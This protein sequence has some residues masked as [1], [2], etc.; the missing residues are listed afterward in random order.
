[1]MDMTS[2]YLH[3]KQQV[4]ELEAK[5]KEAK[6]EIARIRRYWCTSCCTYEKDPD[7]NGCCRRCSMN[8]C[9][10]WCRVRIAR[11]AHKKGC[12]GAAF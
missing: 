8:V 2:H 5:L 1:M 11:P 9:C 4:F 3:A 6:A 12:I 7:E 10:K